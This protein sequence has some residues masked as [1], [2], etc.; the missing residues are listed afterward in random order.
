[1]GYGRLSLRS[2]EMWLTRFGKIDCS[3][4]NILEC[5]MDEMGIAIEMVDVDDY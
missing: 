5:S 1:V 2:D 3:T 4:P